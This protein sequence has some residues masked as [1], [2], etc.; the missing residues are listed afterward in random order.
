[1]KG[2]FSSTRIT[3]DRLHLIQDHSPLE[4]NLCIMGIMVRNG[5]SA[6]AR[7]AVNIKRDHKMVRFV[8]HT[9]LLEKM[10]H[11]S[12]TIV[13]CTSIYLSICLF[14]CIT[15]FHAQFSSHSN[16]GVA[17][18][19]FITLHECSVYTKHILSFRFCDPRLAA[20][21]L[22]FNYHPSHSDSN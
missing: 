18:A 10:G 17:C 9:P 11:Y 22:F 4:L 14:N 8:F 12:F 19:I 15:S 16:F 21:E 5:I 20:M 13:I 2:T 1:M 7:L 6:D 3:F